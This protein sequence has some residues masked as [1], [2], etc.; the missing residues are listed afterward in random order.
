[1][2][3]KTKIVATISDRNCEPEL[4]Q[5]LFNNGM[6]VV[7]L[8]TAHQS[9]EGSL[10]VINNVRKVSDKIAIL[11]D[12]KGPEIRTTEVDQEISV[13]ADEIIKF[14]GNPCQ[15]STKDCIYISYNDFVKDVSVD[16]KILIDD[17]NI[18]LTV[19]KKEED[20]LLCKVE[21]DGV[22]EG[23][24]SVNIP[25]TQ[26]NLPALNQKDI[27][28][29]N[30]AIDNDLDFIAHSFVRRKEDI[31]AVKSI[32]DAKS[33]KIKIIAKIENQEGI[34]NLD[35]ILDYAYGVMVARGDLAIEVPAK[36][37][38]R[39]QKQIVHT[40]IK[41]RKPVIVATQM[42]HTMIKNPR[43]TRAEISDVAN[44][45]YDGADAL[46]LS[47]ETAYGKYP[48]ESVKTMAD[49]AKDI[50]AN[51]ET[52][53]ELPPMVISTQTSAFLVKSAVMAANELPVKAIITDTTSGRTV[54]ALAAFRGKN[55]I[56]AQCYSKQTMRKLALS[57]GVY[58][59]YMEPQKTSHEF[60]QKALKKYSKK[61]IF[62]K[63]NLVLVIAGN[64]NRSK[65][66]NF[67]EIG[68]VG[69]LLEFENIV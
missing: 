28:Y 40:C 3:K 41:R 9:I 56:Y 39:V 16:S 66:A 68:T 48:I 50:E 13:K 6:N 46:M 22:I 36:S 2:K 27:D 64:F 5:E 57:Y 14:K 31:I 18:E 26:I 51:T 65:G 55:T 8:N 67:I 23:K 62:T 63:E 17:G 49:I 4:I 20:Y 34:D 15:K 59:D 24:K 44:A 37:I 29:I 12:T 60:L 42:L 52:Y 53:R 25:Y 47:G 21:N 38:P 32:L 33:S 54:R 58:V 45:V 19:V 1:M 30:F 61:E 11:V 35:E 43:P 7:R 69:D 10:K